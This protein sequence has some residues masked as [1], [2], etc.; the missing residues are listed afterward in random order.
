MQNEGI[1]G[2]S[3]KASSMHLLEEVTSACPKLKVTMYPVWSLHNM[4]IWNLEYEDENDFEKRFENQWID[5][6]A[7][8]PE[9]ISHILS[10]DNLNYESF[11]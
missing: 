8:P 1:L 4:N 6:F 3:V 10:D 2:P 5:C 9:I 11:V 7:N